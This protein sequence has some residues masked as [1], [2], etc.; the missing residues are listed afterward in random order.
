MK[1]DLFTIGYDEMAQLTFNTALIFFSFGLVLTFLL[2]LFLSDRKRN[3]FKQF[4]PDHQ[5][6][7]RFLVPSI[8]AS[9]ICVLIADTL[10][11]S[12]REQP[13]YVFLVSILTLLLLSSILFSPLK[14]IQIILVITILFHIMILYLPPLGLELS[15][16][17]IP[18]T[19]IIKNGYWSSN[20]GLLN[21][22]YEPFPADIGVLT[23][24]SLL[25]SFNVTSALNTWIVSIAVIFTFDMILYKLTM[26]ITDDSRAGVLSVLLFSI[27]PPASIVESL[28]IW[29]GFLLAILASFLLI[30]T[31]TMKAKAG[32]PTVVLLFL[33][34]TLFHPSALIGLFLCAIG[35]LSS[36]IASKFRTAE[37]WR[38]IFHSHYLRDSIGVFLLIFL[39]R[40][41]FTTGYL[42]QI[43]PNLENFLIASFLSPSSPAQY[44]PLYNQTVSPLIAFSWALPV[45]LSA[46]LFLW[47]IIKRK[48]VLQPWLYVM[49]FTASFFLIVGFLSSTSVGLQ[50]ET[51]TSFALLVPIGALLVSRSFSSMKWVAA[52]VILIVAVGASIA[53]MDPII[54]TGG[55]SYSNSVGS[56]SVAVAIP[57]ASTISPTSL[58]I[59]APDISTALYYLSVAKNYPALQEYS[60]TQAVIRQSIDQTVATGKILPNVIYIWSDQWSSN[61]VQNVSNARIDSVF[62]TQ[63]IVVFGS[64]DLL[65]NGSG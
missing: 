56:N 18:A 39:V 26:A 17:T 22:V 57:L 60:S 36:Y 41:S 1:Q 45:G 53:V 48:E 10:F 50:G 15:E 65:T 43:I 42:G 13:D 3:N 32:I 33:S 58:L 5:N 28:N 31:T 12:F 25:T 51:Y 23:F 61:I 52:I 44:S 30:R 4:F 7:S 2:I 40:S 37:N 19:L 55:T 27:I 62:M 14:R 24:T 38:R 11:P 6:L 63:S 16:R 59:V 8:F 29:M 34:A 49:F 47:A 35:F 21:P 54:S 64:A 20:Y 46:S 9:E